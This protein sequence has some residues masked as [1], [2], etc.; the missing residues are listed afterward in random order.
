MDF[1]IHIQE[2]LNDPSKELK[3]SIFHTQ[4]KLWGY[5]Y[6]SNSCELKNKT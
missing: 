2:D 6:Y 5:T 3:R 1:L 4:L